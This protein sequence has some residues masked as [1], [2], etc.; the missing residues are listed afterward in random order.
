[1]PDIRKL[2]ELIKP[3]HTNRGDGLYSPEYSHLIL[4]LSLTRS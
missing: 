4:I 2:R 3:S 1:M